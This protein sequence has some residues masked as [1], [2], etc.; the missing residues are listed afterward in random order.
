MRGNLEGKV[1]IVTGGARGIG[2][3]YATAMSE[4]GATL[5]IVDLMEA[6]GQA[7]ADELV[8]KGGKAK[9]LSVDVSSEQST[10][11]MAEFATREFGGIDILVNNAAIFATLSMLPLE[12]VPLSRWERTLAVN[13]TGPWLCTKAVV[14][15]M[16]KRGGGVIVN[17]SSIG[18]YGSRGAVDY[19]VSK[20]A[21]IGFTKTAAL[22]LGKYNIRVN[23]IAP[24][25]VATEAYAEIMGGL[26]VAKERAQMQALNAVITPEDIAGTLMHLVSDTSRM[27]TGQ[28][29]IV[30]GGKVMLG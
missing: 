1:A 24:G 23:A 3:A 8:A 22:E 12:D 14:P 29:F 26:A 21:V 13:V 28:T 27:V 15:K 20:A 30:D 4:A 18:S 11:A 9:F 6:E 7:T 25:G 19:G 17:Q 2:R 10:Q 16:R 5:L